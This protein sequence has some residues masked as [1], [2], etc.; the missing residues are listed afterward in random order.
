ME[1]ETEAPDPEEEGA[2]RDWTQS[3]VKGQ[4]VRRELGPHTKAPTE[5]RCGGGRGERPRWEPELTAQTLLIQSEPGCL[6]P[7]GVQRGAA[8]IAAETFP[9]QSS[10]DSW[11]TYS[12][13]S[14][15]QHVLRPDLTDS[16]TFSQYEITS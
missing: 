3:H 14:G 16:S 6:W 12:T 13:D 1:K 2:P 8:R 9:T 15:F 11:P 10:A 4:R 7:P 5:W